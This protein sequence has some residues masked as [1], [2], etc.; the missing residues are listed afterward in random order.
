MT[1]IIRNVPK[2]HIASIGASLLPTGKNIVSSL[3]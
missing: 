2:A 1:N 3:L